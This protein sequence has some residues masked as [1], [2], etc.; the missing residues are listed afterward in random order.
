MDRF[1]ALEAAAGP[2]SRETFDSLVQLEENLLKWNK[3]INL[4]SPATA[5]DVWK[6]HIIDSA[7]LYP[8]AKRRRDWID[9]G[10][11]GGFPGL[12][13]ALL[14]A[15]RRDIQISLVESNSKKAAFLQS[16]VG[17]FNLPARVITERIEAFAQRR[18]PP[19]IVS[20]RAL[21]P[22]PELLNLALPWLSATTTGL[23]HKGRDYRREVEESADS[24][25]FNL[26]EHPSMVDS[27]SVILEIA[28]VR[29]RN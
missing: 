17:Q 22:L 24:F 14:G 2:V 7:Q 9:L 20:A 25:D 3:S 29:R 23:F 11:G 27:D 10:S 8:L 6:R 26:I 21:A 16:M 1:Q 15:G 4:I 5:N 18:T 19:D 28:A 12:V 13:I